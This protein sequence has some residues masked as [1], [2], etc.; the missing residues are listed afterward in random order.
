MQALEE[1]RDPEELVEQKTRLLLDLSVKITR[2]AYKVTDEDIDG[3]RSAGWSDEEILEAVHTACLFN[4][5]DRMADTFGLGA[6][7]IPGLRG[8]E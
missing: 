7:S 4:Y 5:L 3:L 8:S 6:L 1:G 2:H